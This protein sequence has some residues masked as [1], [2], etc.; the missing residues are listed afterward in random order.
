MNGATADPWVRT[1]NPPN[2]TKTNKIGSSQYFFLTF[3][4]SQNSL[5][6]SMLELISH[7]RF[8]IFFFNPITNIIIFL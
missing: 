2:K 5:I 6:N 7:A 1:I 4:N 8:Y 3:K